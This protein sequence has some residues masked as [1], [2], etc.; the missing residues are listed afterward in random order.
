MDR[1]AFLLPIVVMS[2]ATAG[3]FAAG[4]PTLQVAELVE[5]ADVIA[6]GRVVDISDVGV[7]SIE[8]VN[9]SFFARRK[10]GTM[11]VA[12]YLKG[13][14]SGEVLQFAFLLPDEPMGYRGVDKDAYRMLF[15]RRAGDAF[16]VA[17]PFYPSL[18]ARPMK[19]MPLN[20]G[21]LGVLSVLR[22]AR[23][24]HAGNEGPCCRTSV[25]SA[26]RGDGRGDS[27]SRVICSVTH[28][29][30]SRSRGA[31]YPIQ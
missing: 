29:F 1:R 14:A 3:I 22:A 16:E 30:A 5:S 6:I 25:C 18:V 17:N 9:G 26:R 13:T 19:A 11:M 21:L 8:T 23:R 4:V 15:L 2:V 31:D 10:I 27:P 20:S 7:T 28:S 24:D 12:Q